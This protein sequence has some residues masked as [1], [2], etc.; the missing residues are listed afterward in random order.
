MLRHPRNASLAEWEGEIVGA[1]QY[2]AIVEG[3]IWKAACAV[4]TDPTRRRSRTNKVKHL[5]ATIAMCE[6][7]CYMGADN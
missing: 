2:P 5:L 3:H 4:L 6:C 1:S 7:L